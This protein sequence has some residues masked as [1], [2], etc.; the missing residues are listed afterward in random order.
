MT[1]P[2]VIVGVGVGGTDGVTVSD[3]VDVT[4]ALFVTVRLLSCVG[5]A[6]SVVDREYVSSLESVCVGSSDTE[7]EMF[8]LIVTDAVSEAENEISSL[9]ERVGLR[10]GVDSRENEIVRDAE[11]SLVN[12]L[13][14]D[15]EYESVISFVNVCLYVPEVS[16]RLFDS[17]SDNVDSLVKDPVVVRVGVSVTLTVKSGVTVIV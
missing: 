6:V 13:D 15:G 8:V 14:E 16:E 4:D 5:V 17:D 10:L 3:G 7:L 2:N 9:S 11:T 1:L 12:E